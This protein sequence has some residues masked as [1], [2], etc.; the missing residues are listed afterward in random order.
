MGERS[1][2]DLTIEDC[3]FPIHVWVLAALKN[4]SISEI[5]F[6]L[7]SRNPSR[8]CSETLEPMDGTMEYF[9]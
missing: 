1:E 4:P 6:P 9:K 8:D 7:I 5:Q 2:I 3:A